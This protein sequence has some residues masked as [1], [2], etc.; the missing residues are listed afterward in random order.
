[1]LFRSGLLQTDMGKPNADYT[2]SFGFTASFAQNFEL[3]ANFDYKWG[4]QTQDLSGM[5][6]RANAVIGRNT[7]L[8]SRLF[9]TMM[10]P[11]SS[12]QERLDAAISWAENIEGLA[13]MSGMNGIYDANLIRFRELSLTYRVP[14]SIVEGWGLSTATLN[15]GGRNLALWMPG[16]DYPG[17]DPETN[18]IGRCN[19]GLNCNFLQGTEGWALPLPRRFTLS[20]RVTF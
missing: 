2:G 16:S 3:A 17:M 18:V 20:T 6:R 10:D 19:G 11:A 8:S 4:G 15:F 12:A 5:F 14:S 9:A 1:M 13:P 7:P